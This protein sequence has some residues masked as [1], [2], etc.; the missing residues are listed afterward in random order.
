MS[1]DA[2]NQSQDRE[3]LSD[4]LA[5]AHV[6]RDPKLPNRD[7]TVRVSGDGDE[8]VAVV[9]RVG[10]GLSDDGSGVEIVKAKVG[11]GDIRNF[12]AAACEVIGRADG[13]RGTASGD[14]DTLEGAVAADV[15]VEPTEQSE[16]AIEEFVFDLSDD[17]LDR[18]TA[19]D[20]T[21]DSI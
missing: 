5:P 11:E 10:I 20:D 17:E 4:L 15:V 7:D 14:G 18:L 9:V 19:P 8:L 6:P 3:S 2:A 16:P 21:L 13:D 12:F 1:Q